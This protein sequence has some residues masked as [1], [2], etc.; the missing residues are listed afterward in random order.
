MLKLKENI[1]LTKDI[2]IAENVE[3][4]GNKL[5]AKVDSNIITFEDSRW[6]INDVYQGDGAIYIL[7]VI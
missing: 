1:D 6:F 2:K 7:E 3:I 4:K 5:T